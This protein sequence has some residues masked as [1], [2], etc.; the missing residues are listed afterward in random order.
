VTACPGLLGAAAAAAAVIL[1]AGCGSTPAGRGTAGP[2]GRPA[3]VPA[4]PLATAAAGPAGTSWA[5]VP[6]G[7]PSGQL[8]NFWQ[9]FVRPAG[10]ARW[11]LATPAGVASN[12]GL[13]VTGTSTGTGTDSGR[14]RTRA[15][16]TGAQALV[17]GFRPSQDL[18]FSPLAASTD[19]G[20]SWSQ[21]TLVSPGLAD[22]PDALAA[23]P[24]GRLIALTDGGRAELGTRLGAAWTQLT[25]EQALAQTAAGRAC[26]LQALTAAGWSA[27]GTPL[28]GG[29]CRTG[30]T[31]GIF[32]ERDGRWQA[33]GPA[34]PAA[35]SGRGAQV[36]DLVS[37]GSR[38]TA[39]IAAGQGPA[40]AVIA[41]WTAAGSSSWSVSGTLLTGA[42]AVRSVSILAGGSAAIVLAGGRGATI[43]GPGRRWRSLP[44]LPGGTATLAAGPAGQPDALAASG[45]TLTAWQLG[46]SG[47][48]SRLQAIRVAIPYGSSS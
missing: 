33:A 28:L 26:A 45:S 20:A 3:A 5:V 1:M 47:R 22:V 2:G 12:G 35:I 4:L 21:G 29:T 27:A 10:S 11:K 36:L 38:S 41:A 13:A 43:A 24:G 19:D 42:R 15:G 34:L 46:G 9:L 32:A 8:E 25:S 48:W 39:V 6:V 23:G 7:G 31:A 44:A 37:S 17:T 40:A 18:T 14:G 16:G 30:G